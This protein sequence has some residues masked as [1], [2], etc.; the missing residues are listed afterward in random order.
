MERNDAQDS[1]PAALRVT[2]AAEAERV[3]AR[4]QPSELHHWV[5]AAAARVARW[6]HVTYRNAEWLQYCMSIRIAHG[7]CVPV[8]NMT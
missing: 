1:Q 4:P 7:K 2:D 6:L 8:F 3:Q 5:V